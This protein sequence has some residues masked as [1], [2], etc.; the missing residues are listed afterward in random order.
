MPHDPGPAFRAL[1]QKGNPFILAN[2]W[3]VGSARM[4]A[5]MGAQALA[6]SS[7][8]YAFTL[9]RPDGIGASRD[10]HLAHAAELVAATDLPVSGDLENGYGPAPEDCADTVRL[11]CE[12]GLAGLCIEDTDLPGDGA[13]DRALAVERIRAAVT[14]RKALPRDMVLIARADGCLTGTYS[15]DEAIARV[16]AFAEAGACGVYIPLPGSPEDLARVVASVEVPVN[17][18]AV[19][20]LA[21]L[22][23]A[24]FAKMGVARISLG[25]SLA[26]IT[27]RALFEAASKMIDSGDFTPNNAMM[28]G[29]KVDALL[30][31]GSAQQ[32]ATT[33]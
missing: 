6:T 12:A 8:A 32:S 25:S 1:H 27:H 23:R 24:D 14:A 18:L 5:A 16:Q 3:D 9:G 26:R 11:A 7:A 31:K 20:P 22:S 33:L 13:Y 28:S 30:A 2:A 21:D 4:L 17:A 19:G 15:L 29:A 10:E